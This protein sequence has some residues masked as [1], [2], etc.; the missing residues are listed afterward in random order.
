MGWDTILAF[1]RYGD[2]FRKHR[3][4][5][6]LHWNQQAT[7]FYRPTQRVEI[8]T[9][10]DNLMRDPKNYGEH[11]KRSCILTELRCEIVC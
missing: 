3:K 5:M 4:L 11:V 1:L 6:Q 7:M 10:L 9:L 2:R 8:H